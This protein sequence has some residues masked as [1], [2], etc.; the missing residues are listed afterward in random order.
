MISVEVIDLINTLF[1]LGAIV[2]QLFVVLILAVLFSKKE[3][4]FIQI[5]QKRALLLSFLLALTATVGSLVYSEIAGYEPCSLCWYQRI[6][7]YPQVI[8]LGM[9]L[10]KNDDSLLKSSLVFSLIGGI[11]AIY[12]TLLQ[13]S[14]SLLPCPAGGVSCAQRLFIKFGYLTIPTLSLTIFAA[15]VVLLLLQKKERKEILA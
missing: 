9:A 6:F 4:K 12:H 7:L 13:F 2:L 14:G 8:L 11:I 1:S 10:M 5:I 3:H 15:L